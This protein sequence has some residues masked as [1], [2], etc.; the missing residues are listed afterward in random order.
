MDKIEILAVEEILEELTK[1]LHFFTDRLYRLKK[2][3]FPTTAKKRRCSWDLFYH[4]PKCKK[5]V[6]VLDESLEYQEH[7]IPLEKDVICS[8]CNNNKC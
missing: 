5:E 3:E 7:K 2:G 8:E 4:C 1:D 6:G